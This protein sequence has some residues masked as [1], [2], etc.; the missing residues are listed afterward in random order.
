MPLRMGLFSCIFFLC[1]NASWAQEQPL[2]D[3][4]EPFGML[5][6]VDEVIIG[7]SED[8]HGFVESAPGVSEIQNIL[9]Q[10]TR[11]M[12]NVGGARFV[13]YRL[14]VGKGLVA[15]QAYVLSVDYPE[16]APRTTFVVNRGGEYARGFSTGAAVGDA[17]QNYTYNNPESLQYPL[18]GEH[19]SWK[20]LFFLHERFNG[21]FQQNGPMARAESPEDG[22]MVYIAQQGTWP[23]DQAQKRQAPLSNGAAVSRIRLFAV[24]DVSS[25][26]ATINYPPEGLPR[27]HLFWRE[28]MS[29]GAVAVTGDNQTAVTNEIDWFENKAKLMKFLGMNTYS[30]DLLEFGANQGWDSTIHGGNDWVHQS[31]TPQRWSN[32]LEM[33]GR[34]GF[35]VL[36]MYEYCGS[37]GDRGLGYQTR[38]RPLRRDPYAGGLRG[39]DT[40][41]DGYT[42]IWWAERCNV[43]IADPETLEDFRKMLDATI[44][45][46]KDRVN[47]LGAWMRVR[48]SSIPVS[49][50]DFSLEMFTGETMQEMPTTRRM[51]IDDPELYARYNE[52]WLGKRRAFLGGT[53][54]ILREELGDDALLLFT[55]Y[56]E[57]PGPSVPGG[58]ITD[59]LETWNEL[60]IGARAWDEVGR[61]GGYLDAI[62]TQGG[63]WRENTC[64]DVEKQMYEWEHSNP[65]PDP[66]NT[67][68]MDGFLFTYPFNRL[69]TTSDPAGFEAFRGPAGVAMLRHYS[70]NENT[71]SVATEGAGPEAILGYFAHDMDRAG[72]YSMLAEAR[73][74]A[75]GDPR[76]IGYLA[77]NRYNRGFPEYVRAFNSAFLALPALPS[78]VWPDAASDTEVVVRAYPTDEHGTYLAVIN[79]GMNSADDVTVTLPGNH[80]V[81]D[82]VTG[83]EVL[84]DGTEFTVRLYPGQVRTLV[85][86]ETMVVTPSDAGVSEVDG[87]MIQMVDSGTVAS[88]DGGEMNQDAR[89]P[90]TT[91]DSPERTSDSGGCNLDSGGSSYPVFALIL[92]GLVA[93]RRRQS[94]PVQG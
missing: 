74:L 26:T 69:Y 17:M 12:P 58:V 14:G 5:P 38:A 25:L 78:N 35:Y 77:S 90:N 83:D 45:R 93:L 33:I 2:M 44:I 76:Y 28:E 20:T 55:A 65:R 70:L 57:E 11:V 36:P 75:Y 6:L 37:K 24:P 41:C 94:N 49:F 15:G 64:N 7:E 3:A 9:G 60:G 10:P 16:D 85:A 84:A 66:S 52:W 42:H 86:T 29:D 22:F 4:G 92:L 27:R 1:V 62:L 53:R 31:R 13:G 32:M 89:V 88:P 34:Y 47:F 79:T 56:L 43:D 48:P 40:P 73:A 51:L 71:M 87:S 19:R 50:S 54:E 80:Q 61:D 68:D 21:Q 91:Q 8:T 39:D 82:A 72:P 23:Q 59:G 30:K 18:A 67:K 46:H 81:I 63:N